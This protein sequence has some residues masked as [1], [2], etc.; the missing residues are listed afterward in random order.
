[1]WGVGDVGE[2]RW[3]SAVSPQ[4]HSSPMRR[5][6]ATEPLSW[7]QSN[8]RS[9]QHFLSPRLPRLEVPIGRTIWTH[10]PQSRH[11]EQSGSAEVSLGRSPLMT[12]QL[13]E[14]SSHTVRGRACRPAAAC[15]PRGHGPTGRPGPTLHS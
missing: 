10:S 2:R 14:D 7:G 5:A 11:T 4:L 12:G 8:H 3:K 1:M 6:V 13:Y 9:A 15:A